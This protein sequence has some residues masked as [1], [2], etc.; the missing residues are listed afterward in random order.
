MWYAVLDANEVRIGKP[1]AFRRL[2]DDLVFWRDNNRQVVAMRDRCPHR[3]AKLSLGKVVDGDIEC[4][5]HGFRYARDGAVT[6]IPANGKNGAK[7]AIFRCDTLTAREAHGL[8]WLWNGGP[9]E[10]YPPIPWF[11]NLEGFTYSTFQARWDCDHTRAIEGMLDVSHLPFVHSKTIG[12]G[13][14]TLVNGPYTTLNNDRIRVW[15]SNQPDEGLPAVK[16][17]ELPEPGIPPSLYFNFPN[18]WQIR[19]GEKLRIVNLSAPVDDENVVI[20]SRTYQN[21]TRIKLLARALT[22]MSNIFN[23]YTLNEDYVVSRSQRPKKSDLNIGEHFIPAD[24]PIALYLQHRRKLMR[25]GD[26]S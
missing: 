13:D 19:L 20:Y 15:I 25:T 10:E 14:K 16:P 2:G 11:D 21:I 8:I 23:R 4:P 18:V 12:R 26:S 7:S 9:R 22:S 24:R 1:Q 3:S 5:F 17:T 6:L